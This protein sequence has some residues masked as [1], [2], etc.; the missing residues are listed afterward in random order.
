LLKNEIGIMAYGKRVRIAHAI[1]DLRR[2]PSLANSERNAPPSPLMPPSNTMSAVYPNSP[3]SLTYSYHS[4]SQSLSQSI[5]GTRSSLGTPFTPLSPEH[6]T[7]A[8]STR[9]LGIEGLPGSKGLMTSPSDSNLGGG[10]TKT[11]VSDKDP[12]ADDRGAFSEVRN[13]KEL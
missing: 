2:P 11:L 9:G 10:E 7:D 3:K 4:R 1:T 8:S 12:S 13:S 6:S 5:A